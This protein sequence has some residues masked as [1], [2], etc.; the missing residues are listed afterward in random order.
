MRSK[1]F[2]LSVLA[3]LLLAAC[4]GNA[5]PAEEPAADQP[6]AEAAPT[7]A[8]PTEASMEE[9]APL[10]A[11][12]LGAGASFPAPI[13]L[14]WIAEYTGN[15]QPGVSINYQS[16]GSGGGVEQF[17]GQ[18][19]A[20]GASDAFLSEE[21]FAAA[22][23]ARGCT[24]VH[25]PT[26]FGAVAL[27]YNLEG[28]E[29]L[30]LSGP[31][32]ADI[33]LGNITSWDD[34]AIAELNPGVDLPAEDI[35]VAHRSDGSG[36]TSI[37][38][39]YLS[40]VSDDWA[41]NVGAGKE[42]EWPAP[43]SVGGEKNDGVAAQIQ[44]NPGAVGYIELSYALTN[45]IPVADM[46]NEDGNAITPTLDSTA[47]AADGITIPDDLRFN[48]LHVGGEGYPIAG[49]T[50]LLAWTCGYDDNTAVALQDWITWNLTEGDDLAK[51]L[52]YSPL[53]DSLQ[54]RAL[55]KVAMI[56]G[57]VDEMLSTG[58][59]M[60]EEAAT[61][62]PMAEPVMLSGELLG[63]GA[64]FPAPIYLEWIAE[65]TGNVQPDVS[66]NY[67]SIGSGGG[68]EQFIGQQ[69]DFGGSDA[70]LSD[71]ELAAATDARGCEPV[72]IPTVFGAVA[73]GYNLE[74][75]DSLTLS[76]PVLADIFLG[77][78]TSWDDPA[79]A[80]LNPGVSLPAEDIIVAH[81]SDGSGTTSIFTTYLSDVSEQWASEVGAGKEVE[82]PAPNSVGGEK[83]DGVAAQ[84][85]QNPG[86]VGYIE[87]SYA[88]TNGIPVADMVNADGNAVTPTLESTAAAADGITIPDDLRFN[89][90]GVGGEGYPIA[91]ATWILAWTCGYEDNTA[92]ML[93]DYLTWTL[94]E[95][96]ALAEELLYS[97]LSASLEARALEKVDMINSAN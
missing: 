33:F 76:G 66:I 42:V 44:Q 72:H 3:I 25:I 46:V 59:P 67:Q 23:D 80:E 96:D 15:V 91:G 37:F 94:T 79:I 56:N 36:T 4:S 32:L 68:V 55:E 28:I 82:W 74:G 61:E 19:T 26:V 89:I 27:G 45:G 34:P 18:Q 64:S 86:A 90:L 78:I 13:Y 53:P 6:A 22:T 65:Y 5:T 1:I 88:L 38:T 21:E 11:E 77:N 63:A 84:I 48:I 30:T 70:F 83:N 62:A 57:G 8:Q 71:E 9:S 14:E 49:A 41:N 29:K 35:I 73:I 16:I 40:S 87:L 12:L 47:A 50:W 93:K 54:A 20:F 10:S 31:V 39:T 85:Q 81:R 60:A 2:I 52:L 69:T 95:G 7:E 92:V 43:N 24:P 97:P 51:E 75:V 17:I 58:E